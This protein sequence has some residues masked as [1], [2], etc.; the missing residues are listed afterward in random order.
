MDTLVLCMKTKKLKG[1]DELLILLQSKKIVITTGV[2]DVPHVGHRRYLSK[3]KELGDVLILI[4]HANNLIN[5]RKGPSRPIYTEKT[6]I[7][8]ISYGKAYRCVDYIL[9]AQ[10]QENVYDAIHKLNPDVLV[11]SVTTEDYENCPKTMIRLFSGEIKVEILEPQS[12][13][14][15]SDLINKR[16]LKKLI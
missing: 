12:E 14:H 11:T 1:F 16:K 15:S 7:K 8:R 10:T 2:F 6:R 4:L 9:I 5:L 3:A 13:L